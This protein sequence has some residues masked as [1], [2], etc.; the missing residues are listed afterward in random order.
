MASRSED[1]PAAKKPRVME[2]ATDPLENKKEDKKETTNAA[3]KNAD[4]DVEEFFLDEI[5][6]SSR[7]EALMLREQFLRIGLVVPKVSFDPVSDSDESDKEEEA[8]P[9]VV[10]KVEPE[11][12]TISSGESICIIDEK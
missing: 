4:V 5:D 7:L 2:D 1:E 6:K 10:P 11:V 3:D 12:I 8:A 9:V